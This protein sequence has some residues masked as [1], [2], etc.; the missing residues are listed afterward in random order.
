[1]VELVRLYSNREVETVR[2]R[3][4]MGATAV[5]RQAEGRMR[6]RQRHRRLGAVEVARLL[7]AY[8]AK[9][10]VHKLAKRFGIHRVTVTALLKRHGIELRHAG[11]APEQVP[12]AATLYRQGWSLVKLGELFGVDPSTIWRNLRAA[13]LTLRSPC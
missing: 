2:L 11:I 10:P 3:L 12:V 9:E 7:A 6:R 4:A 8:Q 1:M 5:Q 13:G